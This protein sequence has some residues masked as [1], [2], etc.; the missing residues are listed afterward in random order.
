[1]KAWQARLAA[2]SLV[3]MI[4]TRPP[5]MLIPEDDPEALAAA[6]WEWLA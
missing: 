4:T 6:L 5:G 2:A 1:V 3:P